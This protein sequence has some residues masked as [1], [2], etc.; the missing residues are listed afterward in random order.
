[1]LRLRAVDPNYQHPRDL[2][3]KVLFEYRQERVMHYQPNTMQLRSSIKPFEIR[4][5]RKRFP[6]VA[7]GLV[8]I[9][10]AGLVILF[11]TM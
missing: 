3:R 5:R 8:T 11:W 7:L 2:A 1:M 6:W 10:G 9:A 4:H